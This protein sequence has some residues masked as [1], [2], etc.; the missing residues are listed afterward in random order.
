MSA[1]HIYIGC[2]GGQPSPACTTHTHI[3][4]VQA[5]VRDCP[6]EDGQPRVSGRPR[7]KA[8]I[9]P[10]FGGRRQ[11]LP[12]PTF[13]TILWLDRCATAYVR[14]PSFESLDTRGPPWNC[15]GHESDVVLSW[16]VVAF[17]STPRSLPP[18]LSAGLRSVC[19]CSVRVCT[20][21]RCARYVWI[22]RVASRRATRWALFVLSRGVRRQRRGRRRLRRVII[23]P[24]QVSATTSLLSNAPSPP[25]SSSPV[26]AA[27]E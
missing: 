18:A 13:R 11:G 3:T 26:A 9:S 8:M 5:R 22:S 7:A 17:S 10:L 4:F 6:A 27:P 15:A 2:C 12:S 1:A 16:G 14:R 23:P 24:T 20:Y 21:K 25:S 19:V